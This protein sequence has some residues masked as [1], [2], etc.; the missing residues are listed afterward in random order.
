LVALRAV[1]NTWRRERQN[2]NALEIA[3]EAGALYDK[4]VSFAED[5]EKLGKQLSTVQKSYDNAWKKLTD[6]R[7][8]IVGKIVKLERLGAKATKSMPKTL[9]SQI[10]EIKE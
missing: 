6:G 2:R 5:L 4:F 3:Q 8:N 1:E 10:E 7:G 9:S